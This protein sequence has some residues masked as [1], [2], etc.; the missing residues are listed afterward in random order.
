MMGLMDVIQ[1]TSN[2]GVEHGDMLQGFAKISPAL[3]IIKREGLDAAKALAPLL[4]MTDQAGMAGEAAGNAYRKIFQ[5]A[6]DTGKVAKGNSLLDGTGVKLDFTNGKGEFGGLDK[7][8]AQLAQL[9]NVTTEKR[10]AALKKV[11]G[12]DAGTLQALTVMIEKGQSGYNDVIKKM[13]DQASL[14]ERVNVQ[15]GT[16]K[17]LWDAASGTFTNAMVAWGESIAP[18]IKALTQWLGDLSEKVGAFAKEHPLLTSVM[19]KSAAVF[20][21]LLVSIG[22]IGI[23][24]ATVMGP[25]AVFRYGWSMLVTLGPSVVSAVGSI[26]TAVAGFGMRVMVALGPLAAL[27]ASFEVGYAIGKK[28]NDILNKSV[29]GENQTLGTW[30]FDKFGGSKPTTPPPIPPKPKAVSASTPVVMKLASAGA[31][32]V[33]GGTAAAGGIPLDNRPP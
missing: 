1:K 21:I 18:E 23:A 8:F 7:M 6:M 32:V 19:M 29:F 15:L 9:K 2:L 17:N 26:G 11:F 31:G 14:Q 24:L 16:L 4:V 28:L 3:S 13:N 25:F 10:L 12:D 22:A 20:A 5:M 33:I 30:V 27:W